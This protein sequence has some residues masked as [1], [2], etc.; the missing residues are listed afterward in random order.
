MEGA[1]VVLGNLT[2]NPGS[3]LEPGYSGSGTFTVTN[4]ATL[5]GVTAFEIGG[6]AN[7]LL[8]A[9]NIMYGGTLSVSFTPGT[10]SSGNTFK[11]FNA[12]HYSGSFGSIVPATPGAGLTWDTSQLTVSGTLRVAAPPQFTSTTLSG[13]NLVMAGSGG[14]SGGSY[15]ILSSTNVAANLS[16]WMSV[17]SGSF[18]PSGT[19]SFTNGINPAVP[20]QFFILVEP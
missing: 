11:L 20:Q 13:T 18:T 8:N 17:G 5:N 7:N 4:T 10:L 3:T 6:G 14:T 2:G 12:A 1:G 19:F 9:T 15:H 16:T